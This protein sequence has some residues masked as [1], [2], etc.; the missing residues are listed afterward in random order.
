MKPEDTP[1]KLKLALI[2]CGEH[3]MENII[4]SLG[5]FSGVKV[6]AV[7]EPNMGAAKEA[8]R[9]LEHCDI[10][11]DI[12]QTLDRDDLDAVIVVAT[13]QVHY[14]VALAALQRKLHVFVEKPPTVSHPQLQLLVNE[15]NARNLVT[16]VG[17]NLRHSSAAL[18]IQSLLKGASPFEADPF[19]R[20][21]QMEMRYLASKPRGDRWGLGSPLR[22]FLLSHANHAIDFM[23]C[24]MGEIAKVN[25]ALAKSDDQGIALSVQF[26]FKS[27]AV[28]NLLATSHAPH[29]SIAGT[30]ISDRNRV[31][32]MN[33]LHEV[34]AYGIGDDAKR[35]GRYWGAKTLL[36]GYDAAGYSKELETF[37]EAIREGNPQLCRPSFSDELEVYKAMEEIE[38]KIQEGRNGHDPHLFPFAVNH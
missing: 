31:L 5:A 11:S 9:R 7:C 6:I 18:E 3:S 14:R 15:A 26:I 2:G 12:E 16:C 35:W 23:I 10:A 21:V 4:P 34:V 27:G 24:Q 25:A 17:H 13:P 8:S 36:T 28:G 29:F 37:F 22:S 20:P 38:R 30:I 33:S 32:Q 19:G 1:P